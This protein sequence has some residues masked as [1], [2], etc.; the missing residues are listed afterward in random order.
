MEVLDTGKIRIAPQADQYLLFTMW[1]GGEVTSSDMSLVREY[2]SRFDGKVSLLV[3]RECHY[4]FSPEAFVMM[5]EEAS[6]FISA[7]AYVD[8][9][10]IDKSYSDYAK[11]T[12]LKD[13]PVKSFPTQQEAESWISQ[14]GPLPDRKQDQP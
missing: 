14:Y 10:S 13:V 8:R 2:F 12:Y 11:S 5:M 3:V 4:S 9:S 7:V 1:S 6:T